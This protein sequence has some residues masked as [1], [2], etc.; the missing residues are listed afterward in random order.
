MPL[1]SQKKEALDEYL[2]IKE[3]QLEL[4]D[5]RRRE[6]AELER[7]KLALEEKLEQQGL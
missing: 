7:L 6:Q 1:F 3:R 5:L 4:E 2:R